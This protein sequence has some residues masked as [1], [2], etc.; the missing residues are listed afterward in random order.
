MEHRCGRVGGS[1]RV[2]GG[3]AVQAGVTAAVRG[4]VDLIP[5]VDK[6]KH[7]AKSGEDVFLGDQISSLDESGMQ[8]M[9]LDETVFTI[10]PNTDLTIDD[11]VY[12]PATGAGQ[13]T[14]SLAKG[15]LRFVTGKVA[16]GDPEDMVVKLPVGTIGI[17]G[18]IGAALYDGVNPALV[19]LLGPGPR[20]NAD[21]RQGRLAVSAAGKTV[22]LT[23]TGWGTSIEPGAQPT[24]AFQFSP[25]QIASIVNQFTPKPGS[26]PADESEGGTA[27]SAAGQ[28]TAEGGPLAGFSGDLGEIS[29]VVGTRATEAATT[30]S[31]ILDG[32]ASIEQLL[33]IETGAF[34]Y[35][36]TGVFTQTTPKVVG[37]FTLH[38]HI[39]FGTRTVGGESTLS[40]SAGSISDSTSILEFSYADDVGLAEGK[41]EANEL[42]NFAPFEGTSA[43]LNNSDG[44]IANT[45]TIDII[46]DNGS[47]A[48]TGG[49]TTGPRVPAVGGV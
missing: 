36:S 16:Q 14:A 4:Q 42:G 28:D 26:E 20:N 15:V 13:V 2:A 32:V 8:L 41:F 48:G 1:V 21:A 37:T 30:S 33:S 45:A 47:F 11:F 22:N 18:T 6:A 31:A 23:R 27:T 49:G 19:V 29:D 12:D 39:N 44:I 46:Y 24:D 5:I 7:R 10:G 9:L 35:N 34:E 38:L 40:V 43:S 3:A 17:R 25:D